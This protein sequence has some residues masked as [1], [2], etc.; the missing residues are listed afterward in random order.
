ME[1]KDESIS[2]PATLRAVSPLEFNPSSDI[3]SNLHRQIPFL[4]FFPSFLFSF[5][6]FFNI[7][8]SEIHSFDVSSFEILISSGKSCLVLSGT[9]GARSSRQSY[10]IVSSAEKEFDASVATVYTNSINLAINLVRIDETQTQT[11]ERANFPT[12]IADERAD[13][14][15]TNTRRRGLR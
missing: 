7:R 11:G 3:S 5:P 13:F 9:S 12:V 2:R 8:G 6:P 1:Q 14:Q 10:L 4:L 15:V